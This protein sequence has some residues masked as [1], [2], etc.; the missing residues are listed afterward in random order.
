[1][2]FNDY[3][4]ALQ[5]FFTYIAKSNIREMIAF[6]DYYPISSIGSFSEPVKMID[7]VN[8][9]NNAAKLYTTNQADAIVEAALD[10]GDAIDGALHATT[11]EKTIYYWRKVFGP[12]FQI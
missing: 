5:S 4:E 12:S 10:A 6:S 8:E 9:E 7:P 2:S 3:P 11:K 1:M